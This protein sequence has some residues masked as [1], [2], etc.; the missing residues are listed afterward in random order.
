MNILTIDFE[1]SCLPCHG[2]SFPIEVGIADAGA[3]CR[4]WLI[5]PHD[6][7]AGWD[8]TSEAQSLHG[9]TRDRLE[10]EGLPV[11]RVIAELAEAVGDRPV[12]ADSYLDAEWLATLA[13]AAGVS[14]PLRIGHVEEVIDR[15]GA[16]DAQIA[17][18][19]ALADAAAFTRHRASG[20]AQWLRAFI[21]ALE[22][23]AAIRPG[24]PEPPMFDWTP[25]RPT[26]P[27]LGAAA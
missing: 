20:D 1:A 7:W 23:I 15:L 11:E 9:L 25:P 26:H 2:R 19:Q 12:I 14:P 18:A 27:A 24:M 17:Q 21:T 6:G 8:W 5:R 3:S 4:A 16:R 10:R 13:A 22:A